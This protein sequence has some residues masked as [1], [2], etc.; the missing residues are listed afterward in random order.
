MASQ[1]KAVHQ[2]NTRVTLWAWQ[3]RGTQL[4]GRKRCRTRAAFRGSWCSNVETL[5]R[6][7]YNLEFAF[8]ESDDL[9][10]GQKSELACEWH[11]EKYA[12]RQSTQRCSGMAKSAHETCTTGTKTRHI[13]VALRERFLVN[14]EETQI[15]RER[16]RVALIRP[17]K[18]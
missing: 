10:A 13:R 17:A 9:G 6:G 18:V 4:R 8:N 15:W 3:G 14:S 12:P 5:T 1:Y 11:F 7:L 2:L 16:T